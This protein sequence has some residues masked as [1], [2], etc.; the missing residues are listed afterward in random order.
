MP[1]KGLSTRHLIKERPDRRPYGSKVEILLGNAHQFGLYKES[2]LFLGNNLIIRL[3][4]HENEKK[5]V[6]KFTA[7]IEG[8]AT[9]SEAEQAG[10][11][12]AMS[13]LWTAISLKFPLRLEYHTP[14]PCV[15][16]DRTPRSGQFCGMGTPTISMTIP[17]SLVVEMLEQIFTSDV[18]V[19][20]KLLVSMELFAAARLE[21]TERARF[22]GLVSAL[23]PLAEQKKL[24][25][26]ALLAIVEDTLKNV[27]ES[28]DIPDNIK[29]SLEGRIRELTRE[30]VSQAINRLIGI[31]LPG[32]ETALDIVREAYGIRSKIL[33]EGSTDAD[34]REKSSEIED[35]IRSLYSAIVGYELRVPAVKKVG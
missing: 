18:K 25:Q 9:A 7:T 13:V 34:L 30:S 21:A 28:V 23:E 2:T 11:R 14:L 3:I 35:V 6:Q 33:H 22:I 8:F 26:P 1:S 29:P 20:Q 27:R 17:E 32:D 16:Y 5:E 15:V 12:F 4:P 31:N 24:E 19:D 10:L